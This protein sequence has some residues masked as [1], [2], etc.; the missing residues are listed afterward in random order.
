MKIGV[1]GDTHRNIAFLNKA[2]DWMIDKQHVSAL[3]H[4][5]DD[6]EDAAGLAERYIDIVQVPG[7]YHP[8]YRDGSLAR[9]GYETLMGLQVLLVHSL[10]KDFDDSDQISADIVLNAHT[11][12]HE[13]RL[14]DGKLFVNPGHLKGERDKNMVPTFAVLT[15][16]DRTVSAEIRDLSFEVVESIE[17]IR[18]ENGLYKAS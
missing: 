9:K 11:H 18:S 8:R 1:V 5:G 15:V 16:Q 6:Y 4:L 14:D 3:Y 2:V 7:I 13:L 12:A 10:E 17:L